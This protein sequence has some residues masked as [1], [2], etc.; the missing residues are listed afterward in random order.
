MKIWLIQNIIAPYRIKL[1]EEI[2]KTKDIDFKL[3]L[4]SKESKYYSHW[5]FSNSRMLFR[6]CLIPGVCFNTSYESE[7]C[8]NPLLLYYMFKEKPNVIICAGFSF[9]TIL[10]LIYRLLLGRPYIIWNEGTCLT[11]SKISFLKKI[12]RRILVHFAGAYIVAGSLSKKYI[13]S[14]KSPYCRKPIFLSYNCVDNTFFASNFDKH[15]KEW[16]S[17]DNFR[18]LYPEKNILFVGALTKGKGIYQLISV[19]KQ[20]VSTTNEHIG[21]ILVGEGPLRC[22]IENEKR[23]NDLKY[24]FIEGF[25]SYADLPKYYAIANVFI[26]LSLFDRN[27]LVLFEALAC[28]L[29]VI[30]SKNAG[31]A[32]DFIENG[33]NGFIVD[34][35][36]TDD[37]IE[38][39]YK[40][41]KLSDAERMEIMFKSRKIVEKANY[42]NSADAFLSACRLCWKNKHRY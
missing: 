37:I 20:I 14:L 40:L 6:A 4:L 8:L 12:I 21:L 5:K 3:I 25:I 18:K 38:K 28:G 42:R 32:V 17:N 31:N 34:P 16:K 13:E 41:L 35:F 23:I 27:P 26:L 11:E 30:C 10:A 2:A 7:I 15:R 22:Y 9:A 29:P 24:I 36:D 1:F 33:K 39:T 19:Y